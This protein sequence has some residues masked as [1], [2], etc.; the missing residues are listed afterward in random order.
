MLLLSGSACSSEAKI[1][2]ATG[3]V[4]SIEDTTE[5]VYDQVYGCKPKF[6]GESMEIKCGYEEEKV[7]DMPTKTINVGA[8]KKTSDGSLELSDNGYLDKHKRHASDYPIVSDG[9]T[10]GNVI[11]GLQI[12]IPATGSTFEINDIVDVAALKKLA[13]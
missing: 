9:K 1:Y 7:G 3:S 2:P 13:V 8:C 12:E 5:P 6:T 4:I 10:L 11:C